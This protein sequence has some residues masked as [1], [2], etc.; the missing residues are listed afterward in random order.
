MRSEVIAVR[1]LRARSSSI[2]LTSHSKKSGTARV[3]NEIEENC[4]DF[5]LHCMCKDYASIRPWLSSVTLPD[6]AILESAKFVWLKENLPKML[7]QGDRVLIFSQWTTI[8]DIMETFL[9]ILGLGYFRIDGS[10]PVTERQPLIDAFNK[11]GAAVNIF[12]L[13]TRAGGMGINLTSANV[14]VMHDIDFNPQ[15]DMQAQD[16]CHRIGQTREVK[17]V[18]L[19]VR[20]TVDEQIQRIAQRKR[21]LHRALL[22]SPSKRK[23]DTAAM[24]DLFRDRNEKKKNLN[25]MDDINEALDGLNGVKESDDNDGAE[26]KKKSSSSGDS[27]SGVHSDED[28]IIIIE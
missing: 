13:S 20:G 2:L 24:K 7:N 10:T 5:Y 17:V 21:V 18:R 26:K 19:I 16:R 22:M 9:D 8:L 3:L 1:S 14:V 4:S 11:T 23:S 28:G 15:N 25:D 27:S 12:L 6:E